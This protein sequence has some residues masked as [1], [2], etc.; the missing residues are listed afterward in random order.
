MYRRVKR[1]QASAMPLMVTEQGRGETP[2]AIVPVGDARSLRPCRSESIY[3]GRL[4]GYPAPGDRW[5]VCRQPRPPA[6]PVR[7]RP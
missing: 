7:P 5:H 1:L 4:A 3:R 2:E 6:G